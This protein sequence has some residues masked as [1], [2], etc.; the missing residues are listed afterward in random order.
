MRAKGR[1]LFV[2]GY[3]HASSTVSGTISVDLEI[4]MTYFFDGSLGLFELDVLRHRLVRWC[5]VDG[6]WGWV[7]PRRWEPRFDGLVLRE[8]IKFT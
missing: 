7:V 4:T 6:G 1:K 2:F 5:H 8:Q 3:D